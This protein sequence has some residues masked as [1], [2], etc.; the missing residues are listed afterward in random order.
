MIK[1]DVA[2]ISKHSVF[3]Q[4]DI[5]YFR[6]PLCLLGRPFSIVKRYS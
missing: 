3:H 1:F 6:F 5:K 2:G 4:F